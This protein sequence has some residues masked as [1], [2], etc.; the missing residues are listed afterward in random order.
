MTIL[1]TNGLL[2]V[3]AQGNS[4]GYSLLKDKEIFT[5]PR[6]FQRLHICPVITFSQLNFESCI[7][8]STVDYRFIT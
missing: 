1:A 2:Q 8:H 4:N 3:I 5:P 6:S 7:I